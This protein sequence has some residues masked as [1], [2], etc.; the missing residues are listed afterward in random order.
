MSLASCDRGDLQHTCA[1]NKRSKLCLGSCGHK[2]SC[3]GLTG[4]FLLVVVVSFC[5]WWPWPPSPCFSSTPLFLSSTRNHA[6]MPLPSYR[7]IAR[8]LTCTHVACNTLGFSYQVCG[9]PQV[10]II[11]NEFH[12]NPPTCTLLRSSSLWHNPYHT[13][14]SSITFSQRTSI[15][16]SYPSAVP[17]SKL[18]REMKTRFGRK[19]A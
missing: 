18:Q 17:R 1:G 9:H 15:A 3:P 11:S 2:H 8:K 14:A 19:S 6:L 5:P 4:V 7:L 12:V 10:T 16:R 13:G